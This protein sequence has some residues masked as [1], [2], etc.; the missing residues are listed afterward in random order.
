MG[1]PPKASILK[2][3]FHYKSSIFGVPIFLETPKWV[4]IWNPDLVCPNPSPSSTTS[5][6]CQA[7]NDARRYSWANLPKNTIRLHWLTPDIGNW[8]TLCGS[9]LIVNMIFVIF[10]SC[11][12]RNN[13]S[14]APLH[15]KTLP[16]N[17]TCVWP[18]WCCLSFRSLG[19]SDS[20]QT[21]PMPITILPKCEIEKSASFFWEK[22]QFQGVWSL[23]F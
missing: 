14:F 1:F 19:N 12:W 16:F 18:K 21:I 5:L 2:R 3:V 7:I 10:T 4:Q 6:F 22:F 23:R 13:L 15:L 20:R 11:C 17:F 9:W 8:M